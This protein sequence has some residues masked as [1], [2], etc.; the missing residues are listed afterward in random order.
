[1]KNIRSWHKHSIFIAFFLIINLVLAQTDVAY[2]EAFPN[3]SFN[4]PVEMQGSVD[5]SNRIFVVE[6]P[7][8]IKVFPNDRNVSSGQVDTYLDIS[9]TVSYSSGQEIGL[10]GLAFHPNYASNGFVF[11]YY[12]DRPS[13][14]RINIARYTVSQTNPNVLDTATGTIIAQFTKNQGDSNHNGGKIA[15]GPDGYLY[16]S[17]GDGG[18]GGDPQGNGQNLNTVFGSLLRIDIDLDGNNPTETNPESPSGNYE[19]PS[20]NPRVGLS[21]LDELY[22][23]GIR[24]TWKFSFD[25]SGNLWGADV[26]QNTYEEINLITRG[27]NYGWNRFE[28]NAQPSYGS[29]TTLASSP[30]V[31]PIL[32]YDHSAGDVSITGGYKYR[33]SLS[34]SSLQDR[35]IYGDYVSGRVWGLSY[36]SSAGA[37]SN[38]LL[39]K[40][41]GQFISSFGEDENGELYFLDYG[42]SVKVYRITGDNS[43]PE[44]T[45]VAV[46]GIGSW[47]NAGTNSVNGVVETIANDGADTF[48]VG[49]LF[50]QAS[51]LTVSNLATYNKATGWSTFGSGTNGKVSSIAIA[52]NG[53][54]YVGGEFSI[55]DGVSVSNIAFWDG[56]NWNSM[57]GGTNG[58]V[59]KIKIDSNNTVYVGGAFET[60]G[61]IN[62]NNIARWSSGNWSALNDATNGVAG[63]NNEIRSIAF[64]ESDNL[65]IGGN[66]DTAGGNSAPRLAIWNGSNWSTLGNGT[67]GFVQGILIRPEYIYVGGNFSLA[68]SETVNRIARWNRNTAAWESLNN[69]LSGSANSLAHDGTY[70]YVGGT[71]ETASDIT[72]VNEI[73]N[74][75]ARYSDTNGWEALGKNTT[76]GVG[77]AINAL[78]FSTDDLSL[79][80]GGNFTSTGEISAKNVG[81]WNIDKEC[82]TSS[83]TP[84]Y[85]INGNLANGENQINIAENSSFSLGIVQ[86]LYFQITLPD[87]S[88]VNGTY[89]ISS[90]SS[91]NSGTYTI[92]STEGCIET[93]ILNVK[94]NPNVDEDNDGIINSNDICSNTPSGEAVDA[95][96]C[97]ESQLDTDGDGVNNS[98]DNCPNT[99]VGAIVSSDGCEITSLPVNQ[100]SITSNGN[101]CVTTTNGRIN[102]VSKS[103]GLYTAHLITI[104]ES[105]SFQFTDSLEI[106][107]LVAGEYTLCITAQDYSDYENCSKIVITAPQALEVDSVLDNEL[108]LNSVTLKMSGGSKYSISLNGRMTETEADEITLILDEDVNTIKVSTGLTCQGIYEETIVLKNTVILYPNPATD[109]VAIDLSHINLETVRISLYSE[110]GVQLSSDQFVTTEG[111]ATLNTSSLAKGIYFIRVKNEEMDKALKLIKL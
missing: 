29:G 48:Y 65:Y 40:T 87:N 88:T 60:A 20:D 46:N 53:T 82:I 28:A 18:G 94:L 104:D 108:E 21:G 62:V 79:Y 110:S 31:K 4:F 100:F 78:C 27:G 98:N 71:F 8:I 56:S 67:S 86:D 64:D 6:Q 14:Y 52:D 43:D 3:I 2:Q 42:S 22:A 66:F 49:G 11:V 47:L 13:N 5:G 30:D 39:F 59:S 80:A 10:L 33:G 55:I 81:I 41:N 54:V 75:I 57:N 63:T 19:I 106:E 50:S 102:V 17:I 68:G 105:D 24:N 69:G 16:I 93:F 61:G 1:M 25:S 72:N 77:T 7:G 70:L 96:G 103:T 111:T 85:E 12:I 109:F 38:D 90:T 99:P 58:P 101:S 84:E 34:N 45:T 51:G 9:S 92:T 37:T 44:P 23:W 76:V 35:Y 15:F 74:N 26:G 107:G 73:M 91:N 36:N 89:S 95:D 97:S 83:I 32:F